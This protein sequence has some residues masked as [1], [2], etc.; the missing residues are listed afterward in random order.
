MAGPD[1][2]VGSGHGPIQ[3]FAGLWQRGGLQTRPSPAQ[4]A[5]SWWH[6]IRDIR[7][8]TD[9]LPFVRALGDGSLH[10]EAF[11]WYLAQDALYLHDYAR[12]LALAS[13]LAP[14]ATEQ[15]FW[16]ASAL[17]AIAAEL[18]LHSSW[19][20]DETLAGVQPSETTTA[21]LNHLAAAGAR[22]DYGV[23]VAALLPCFWMYQDVGTRLHPLSHDAH[24]YRSWLDT[25]ADEEFAASTAR[26]IE[27]V[28]TVAATA[29]EPARHHMA[30]AFRVS[31]GH[32]REFFAAPLISPR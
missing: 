12:M 24:P 13:R 21:Y 15:A 30:Q 5:E 7:T 14:T 20:A 26:A 25:Y 28:T 1:L 17:G 6:D 18:D 10:R 4:V 16:A 31:A 29:D 2:Q 27:I 3:H 22:G 8:D 19:I 32:E 9:E 11:V 23:L